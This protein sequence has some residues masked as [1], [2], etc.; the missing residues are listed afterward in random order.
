MRFFKM[1]NHLVVKFF[2]IVLSFCAVSILSSPAYAY[3]NSDSSQAL[4]VIEEEPLQ[5][6]LA[7]ISSEETEEIIPEGYQ[8]WDSDCA[9]IYILARIFDAIYDFYMRTA[10]L[11]RATMRIDIIRQTLWGIWYTCE[12]YYED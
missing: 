5:G 7:E 10:P 9:G 1:Q 4:N 3:Q 6:T 8:W 12:V 11:S 2:I